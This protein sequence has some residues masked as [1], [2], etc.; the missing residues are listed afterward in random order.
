[1]GA[2]ATTDHSALEVA[3]AASHDTI[4]KLE[5]ERDRLMAERDRLRAAHERLRLELELLRRRLFVAKAERVDT[6]QLEL[7]FMQTLAEL[8]RLGGIVQAAPGGDDDEKAPPRGARKKPTGRRDLKKAPLEEERIELT[9]PVFEDLVAQGK[10]E[11]I[12]FADS[13]KVAWKRGG[14]R[15]LVVARA[16]YRAVDA[17]GEAQIET[18]P[19]PA[20]C[21]PR[22]MAAPSMLAHVITDKYCDGL[23][24]HR[25]QVGELRQAADRDEPQ[26]RQLGRRLSWLSH[27]QRQEDQRALHPGEALCLQP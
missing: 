25:R 20:E 18:T 3:L 17:R 15:R 22:S 21:F 7:E 24:L 6:A 13:C 8:D 14:L 9:D 1:V 16:K 26:F 10:A 2:V 4:E 27:S 23:P 11:R 19:V 5:A 12:G